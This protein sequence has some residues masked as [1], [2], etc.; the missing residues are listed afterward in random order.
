MVNV[1]VLTILKV[2]TVND[3]RTFTMIYHGNLHKKMLPTLVRV[4]RK[5]IP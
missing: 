3:V 4:S 5:Q 2:I 1:C